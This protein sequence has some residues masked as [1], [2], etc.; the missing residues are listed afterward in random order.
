[1]PQMFLH[2]ARLLQQPSLFLLA[3]FEGSAKSF[4]ANGTPCH[5]CP[6]KSRFRD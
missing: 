4:D 2:G 3:L 6:V 5:H 1:M